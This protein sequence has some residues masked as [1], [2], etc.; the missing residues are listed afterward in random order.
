MAAMETSLAKA[1]V[2]EKTSSEAPHK[3]TRR[4]DQDM[5]TKSPGVDENR[6]AVEPSSICARRRMSSLAGKTGIVDGHTIVTAKPGFCQSAARGPVRK[7][8]SAAANDR[9]LSSVN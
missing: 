4:P 2:L 7:L 9:E 5:M 8:K 6:L 1:T 3:D